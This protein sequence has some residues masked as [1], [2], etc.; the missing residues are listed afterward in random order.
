MI[1]H[2]GAP[3]EA[4]ENTLA[5]FEA[6]LRAGVRAVE[7]DARLAAD[8]V[9]VVHHDAELG[10]TIPGEGRI[11]DLAAPALVEKGIPLL[12]AVLAMPLLVNVEIKSDA[13]NARELPRRVLDVV[14]R[15]DALERVLVTSFDHEIADDYARLSGRPAGMIVPYAPEEEL[16]SFPRLG[17]VALAADA[18]LPEAIAAC[19]SAERRV[20]VWTVNDEKSARGFL[21][22]GASGVI[23]DRPGPLARAIAEAEPAP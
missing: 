9:V 18:A 8:G 13:D 2:R 21:A 19:R 12:S 23:T 20:L 11:E 4:L 6:C 17:F 1:G 15:A 5:S 7:L 3:R 10:R 22:S 16:A 14:Q